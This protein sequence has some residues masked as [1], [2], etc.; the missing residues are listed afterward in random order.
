[1]NFF[2]KLM[3]TV[4]HPSISAMTGLSLPTV[5]LPLDGPELRL[6]LWN[7][8]KLNFEYVH[9]HF[10][11]QYDWLSK[12][13]WTLGYLITANTIRLLVEHEFN[14]RCRQVAKKLPGDTNTIS[15]RTS[16]DRFL[17]HVSFLSP[18]DESIVAFALSLP[19][20][21]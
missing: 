8:A 14:E 13:Y 6:H 10:L 4:L 12:A 2:K 20:F 9:T 19:R 18:Q 15:F 3:N 21:K 16:L 1:M 7:E 5:G 11:D 17:Q